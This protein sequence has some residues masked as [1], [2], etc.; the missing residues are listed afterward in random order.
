MKLDSSLDGARAQKAKFEELDEELLRFRN[1][2]FRIF[3]SCE[4]GVQ[5]ARSTLTIDGNEPAFVGSSSAKV[6]SLVRHG[7]PRLPDP[8]LLEKIVNNR[9]KR[10]D[11]FGQSLLADPAWDMI[12]DLAIARARFR[13]VS[14]SSL[15]I[16]SG[17]PSTTALRWIGLMVDAGIF[18]REEDCL[19]RRRTYISL[20][21]SAVRKVAEYFASLEAPELA[22]VL[23]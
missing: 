8:H 23:S 15:C 19:D 11:F 1:T 4:Q 7:K 13:R 14:V 6:D 5:K 10:G 16:A 21:D 20:T 22:A 9:R 3:Q 17:V 18:K 12:L 2:L